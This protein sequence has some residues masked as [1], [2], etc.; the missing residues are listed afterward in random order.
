MVN[1]KVITTWGSPIPECT[2]LVAHAC[3]LL[4]CASNIV[5]VRVCFLTQVFTYMST[6]QQWDARVGVNMTKYTELYYTD[7]PLP[8]GGVAHLRLDCGLPSPSAS[9][10]DGDRTTLP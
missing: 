2:D 10:S 7:R 3:M 4:C 6:C 9:I 1:K 5:C 8:S